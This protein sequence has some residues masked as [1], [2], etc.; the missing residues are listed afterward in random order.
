MVIHGKQKKAKRAEQSG[1]EQTVAKLE[2]K[3]NECLIMKA[4][5][6]SIKYRCASG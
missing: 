4:G 5:V 3:R 2:K 6:D 1:G